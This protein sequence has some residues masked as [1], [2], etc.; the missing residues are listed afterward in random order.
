MG[1]LNKSI[2]IIGRTKRLGTD[3]GIEIQQWLDDNKDL[4]IEKFVI[5]DDDMDMEHLLRHLVHTDTNIGM[6]YYTYYEAKQKLGGL[7]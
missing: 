2:E 1:G 7:I 4:D 6:T 3:R 5:L